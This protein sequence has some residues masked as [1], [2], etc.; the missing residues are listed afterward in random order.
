[1]TVVTVTVKAKIEGMD[2]QH[3]IKFA[4]E[5]WDDPVAHHLPMIEWMLKDIAKDCKKEAA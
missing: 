4:P 2:V 5:A 1:M 3:E